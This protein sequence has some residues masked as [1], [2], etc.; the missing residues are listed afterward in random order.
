MKT[1]LK[2]IFFTCLLIALSACDWL[3]YRDDYP[4]ISIY[5]TNGDYF[6]LVTIGMKEGNVVR[7]P[8]FLNS[9][10]KFIIQGKDT[11]YKYRIR[12]KNG[13][14]LDGEATESKDVFLKLNFSQYKILEKKLFPGIPHDSLKYYIL[15]RDPYLE[16]YQDRSSSPKR[17]GDSF[18]YADTAEINA[19]ILEGKL[20]EYFTKLK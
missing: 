3:N 8:T 13:Y 10:D 5:K 1:K 12:L 6:D 16:F 4:G 7:T 18:K 14:V 17:F 19:I 15:D 9:L 20:N 2:I 11:I